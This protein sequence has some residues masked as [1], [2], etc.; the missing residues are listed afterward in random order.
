MTPHTLGQ[1]PKPV[2]PNTLTDPLPGEETQHMKPLQGTVISNPDAP[3]RG[4]RVQIVA[5]QQDAIPGHPTVR[6]SILD[7]PVCGAT[8]T[9]LALSDVEWDKPAAVRQWVEKTPEPPASRRR[10]E[11]S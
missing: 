3:L 6:C 5:R 4:H 7:G 9:G 11:P 2:A 10:G 8:S 1:F